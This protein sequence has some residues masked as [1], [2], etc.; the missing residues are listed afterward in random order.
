MMN[1]RIEKG[2]EKS[3]WIHWMFYAV[4][5][6]FFCVLLYWVVRYWE[7]MP[8]VDESATESALRNLI[9]EGLPRVGVDK[10][11]VMYDLPPKVQY[12]WSYFV[13]LLLRIPVQVIGDFLQLDNLQPLTNLIFSVCVLWL[14]GMQ[15]SVWLQQGAHQEKEVYVFQA[16][17]LMLVMMCSEGIMSFAHYVRYYIF[18]MI[19]FVFGIIMIPIY[20]DDLSDRKN[21]WKIYMLGILPCVFHLLYVPYSLLV[22]VLVL[23]EMKKQ[24][25][26]QW[27]NFVMALPV[28]IIMAAGTIYLLAARQTDVLGMIHISRSNLIRYISLIISLNKAELVLAGAVLAVNVWCFRQMSSVQKKSVLLTGLN[29]LL[30]IIFVGNGIYTYPRYCWPLRICYIMLL[31]TAFVIVIEKLCGR[32]QRKSTVTFM[33]SFLCILTWGGVSRGNMKGYTMLPLVSWKEYYAMEDCV[34]A[35]Q[36]VVFSDCPLP[37]SLKHPEWY[38]YLMR[39][40]HEIKEEDVV[41]FNGSINYYRSSRGF[42]SPVSNLQYAGKKRDIERILESLDDANH[43]YFVFWNSQIE[44]TD[45]QVQSFF[46]NTG[47]DI[48]KPIQMKEF[49]STWDHYFK[50]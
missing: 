24:K 49:K 42:H 16:A 39:D 6:M 45:A 38:V 48:S 46:Q 22:F 11:S 28:L 1:R 25:R 3:S 19:T 41:K 29:I 21:I 7:Y 15:I 50:E 8:Y 35:K 12:Y 23:W 26:L 5:G 31:V 37:V 47:M 2:T 17:M 14:L 9:A 30:N 44:R 32:M 27:K 40:Y 4:L 43:T 13:E 18:A 33:V 34:K 20:L 36:V 10:N